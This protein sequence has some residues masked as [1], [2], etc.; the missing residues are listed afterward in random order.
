VSGL[1][2]DAAAT[3]YT[4]QMTGA[5]E[6]SAYSLGG[7]WTHYGP[8]GWYLDAVRSARS[9]VQSPAAANARNW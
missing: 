2:T 3:A 8:S 4:R 5:V 7:Y 1:V 9:D 6:L